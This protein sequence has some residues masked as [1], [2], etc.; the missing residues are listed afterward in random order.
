VYRSVNSGKRAISPAERAHLVS[1]Y[2]G[3][4][5]SMDAGIADLLTRLRELGLY[6]NTLIIVTADHG[7]AFG[8]RNLVE[9]A[10]GSV[11]QEHVHVPLLI[12]YPGESHAETSDAL[13]SQVDLMPTILDLAGCPLPPGLQ[14]LSLRSPNTSAVVYSEAI[15][16]TYL[17]AWNARFRA[18]R[19][20]AI[21]GVWKL[22][23]PDSGR[24]ELYNMAEDPGETHDLYRAGDPNAA[25]LEA[26]LAAWTAAFPKPLEQPRKLDKGSVDRLK[27]LGYVQ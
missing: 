27:S 5:A 23:K 9:H 11:Y 24:T 15:P 6:Q 1:Q 17:Q 7:E 16:L 4:I 19:R 2:D 22:I 13:V 25:A 21:A 14:G 26:R 18:A 10:L 8:E 20:A 3:G 12:K